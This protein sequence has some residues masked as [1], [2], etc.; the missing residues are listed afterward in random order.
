MAAVGSR[1][2][3]TTV[4]HDVAFRLWPHGLSRAVRRYRRVSYAVAIRRSALLLCVSARTQHDLLGLYGVSGQR[5]QVWQP[6]S[7]LSTVPGRLPD[8]LAAVRQ[9]GGRYVVVVGHAPH[10]GAELAISA[11]ARMPDLVLAVLTGGQPADGFRSLAA[12]SGASERVLFLD[13]LSDA[14]YA[15]TVTAATAFLMPS[16]FEGYGLPAVEALR[17]G[18]PAVIS[19]DPALQEATGGSA[20]RMEGWTG[21][22]LSRAIASIDR[23]GYGEGSRSTGLP[24]RYE[25]EPRHKPDLSPTGRSWRAATAD[26]AGRLTG[27]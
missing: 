20:V 13:R 22:A 12:D 19:P 23:P 1:L 18:T 14:D 8:A 25:P 16:H 2:P 4:V 7:D 5:C 15:A 21:E 9:R 11:V 6:G 26:L 3:I 24:P 17:L 10:K 27:R